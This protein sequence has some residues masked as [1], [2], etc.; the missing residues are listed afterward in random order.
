MG[1]IGAFAPLNILERY[2]MYKDPKNH[3]WEQSLTGRKSIE[4]SLSPTPSDPTVPA[5]ITPEIKAGLLVFQAHYVPKGIQ[6]EGTVVLPDDVSGASHGVE[7]LFKFDSTKSA[8]V[9]LTIGL[10][11]HP[12]AL[13]N[14]IAFGVNA[15]GDWRIDYLNSFKQHTRSQPMIRG[16]DFASSE[17][18]IEIIRDDERLHFYLNGIAI[19]TMLAPS[20]VGRRVGFLVTGEAQPAT[21]QI[22]HLI[23]ILKRRSYPAVHTQ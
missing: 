9:W 17:G 21:I 13:P 16:K 14:G 7:G 6:P 3:T 19:H 23:W 18:A 12:V 10:D 22:N 2:I 11:V 4:W 1:V 5:A 8:F 15:N 20:Y